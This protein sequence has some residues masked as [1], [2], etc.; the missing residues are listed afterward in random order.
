MGVKQ[1]SL[2]GNGGDKTRSKI[3]N[4]IENVLN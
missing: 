3:H 2:E 1:G 4:F